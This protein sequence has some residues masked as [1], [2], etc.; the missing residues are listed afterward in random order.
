MAKLI[1]VH[2]GVLIDDELVREGFRV[3]FAP[4]VPA[5]EPQAQVAMVKEQQRMGACDPVAFFLTLHPE[6]SEAQAWEEIEE[7]VEITAKFTDMVTTR[8]LALGDGGTLQTL[9]QAAGRIGGQTSGAVRREARDDE[10]DDDPD[11]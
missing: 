1:S 11:Q 2:G 7:S 5:D 10:R 6:L 3:R 8:G 9:Q 4:Y